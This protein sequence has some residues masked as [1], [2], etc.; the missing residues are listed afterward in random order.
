MKHIVHCPR[1]NKRIL[2]RRTTRYSIIDRLYRAVDIDTLTVV[3][4]DGEAV[5]MFMR[6]RCGAA[7]FIEVGGE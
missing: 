2:K 7:H 3:Q 4:V 1:C 5:L 6:C